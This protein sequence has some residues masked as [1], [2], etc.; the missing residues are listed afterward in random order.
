[1]S[2]KHIGSSFDNYLMDEGLLEE[3]EARAIKEIIAWQLIEEMEKQNLSKATMAKRMQTSRSA[4]DRLLDP[5]NTSVTLH[6]MQKAAAVLGI[7]LRLKLA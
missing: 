1:M 2:N 6:T 5:E 4:L 7:H 3:V